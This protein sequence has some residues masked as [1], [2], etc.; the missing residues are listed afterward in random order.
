[1]ASGVKVHEDCLTKF[2]DLRAGKF[3]Y[4]LFKISQDF[5]EIVTDTTVKDTTYD[6]FVASLPEG[7]PRFAVYD[8]EYEKPGE[9]HR[10]KLIFYSWIPD[11][12]NVKSKMIYASSKEG[13]RKKLETSFE[14]QGTEPSEVSY[15]TVLER[16]VRTS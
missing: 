2:K 16:A 3:K 15:E 11:T 7:E 13:F 9:G 10:R 5:E 8:F 12:A 4:I 6:E 14:I 1:M